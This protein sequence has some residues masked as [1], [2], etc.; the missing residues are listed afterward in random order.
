MPLSKKDALDA[1]RAILQGAR[2]AEAARLNNIKAWMTPGLV[3]PVEL[4]KDAPDVMRRLAAKS[5][6]NYLPLVAKSFS[7]RLKVQ[8]IYSSGSPER[9]AS[10]KYWTR[11][12]MP[13]R[14]TA[15][16]RGAIV[17]GAAYELLLPGSNGPVSQGMSPRRMTAVYQDPAHDE[18]PMLA[19]DVDGQMM[20]L[21][22]ETSIYYIGVENSPRGVFEQ[23]TAAG[24][25]EYIESRDHDIGVC[26]VVRFQDRFQH[27]GEE[28]FGLIEPLLGLQARIHET[29][30]GLLVTQFFAA[31]KQRYV[32]GWVPKNEAE[33]MRANASDVWYFDKPDVKVGQFDESDL[34]KYIESKNDA[35]RDLAAIAQVSMQSLG[36]DGISNISAETLASLQNGQDAEGDEISTSLGQS[37][38]QWFR[39]ASFI[40]GDSAGAEDFDTETRWM[41]ATARS[42]AQAV[43]G[44]GKLAQMLQ[45]PVELLWEKIPDMSDN[46]IKRAIQMRR[47]EQAQVRLQGL[48]QAATA[49]RADQQVAQAAAQSA[50]A[51]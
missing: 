1:A 22:D 26:P 36:A 16:H 15:T 21:I 4:P 30:F 51:Q 9:L 47:R 32:M 12:G 7:Q 5:E 14:Q 8:G 20:R 11:N 38:A 18:W 45:V 49:A 50:P 34:S 10:W 35:K 46:D 42:F 48:S 29:T 25:M 3:P 23:T 13:A 39:L 44:L 17:Y 27:D 6:T 37:W 40:D 31:F 2:T 28:V 41:D 33:E 19:L 43:D 24:R